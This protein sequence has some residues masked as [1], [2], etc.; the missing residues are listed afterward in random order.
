MP[1]FGNLLQD[2]HSKLVKKKIFG[3]FFLTFILGLGIYFGTTALWKYVKEFQIQKK[4]HDIQ[5]LVQ[6]GPIYE[7]LN[8]LFLEEILDLSSDRPSNLFTFDLKEAKQKLL[9]SHI[10]QQVELKKIKPNIVMVDYA[11]RKPVGF[12]GE[13]AN[14]A[15]DEEGKLFPFFPYFRPRHLP[16]VYFGGGDSESLWGT[17]LDKGKLQLA[18]HL[19]ASLSGYPIESMDLS[20]IDHPSLG[21]KEMIVVVNYQPYQ[22]FLRIPVHNFD[23]AIHRYGMLHFYHYI[24]KEHSVIVDLRFPQMAFFHPVSNQQ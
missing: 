17:T 12:L 20:W 9:D 2:S 8:S 3:L 14:T 1:F 22:H 11:L 23:E 6:T 18:M 24:D 4:Q 5:I 13:F 16:K 7:A 10:I 21:K 19:L 15:W